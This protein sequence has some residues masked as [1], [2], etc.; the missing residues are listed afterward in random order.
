MKKVVKILMTIFMICLLS[1]STL[2][3]DYAEA[4][5]KVKLNKTNVT[6]NVGDTMKLKLSGTDKKITWSSSNKKVVK[7]NKNGKITALKKGK[8][9]ITAKVGKKEYTCKVKVVEEAKN[10]KSVDQVTY[11]T[12]HTNS[13]VNTSVDYIVFTVKEVRKYSDGSYQVVAYIYNGFNH[14]V[15]NITV[16]SMS[17]YDKN[18]NLAASAGFEPCN[19]LV[20]PGQSYK[21]W[22]FRFDS[23]YTYKGDFD[24][25]SVS[26]SEFNTFTH[27]K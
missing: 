26:L 6:L 15:G 12:V 10:K 9:N 1:A 5:S 20:I 2:T 11:E 13:F 21:E 7:V 17:L 18:L 16:T 8:A 3:V 25:T 27:L 24:F 14:P 4:A 23:K 22:I 19:G